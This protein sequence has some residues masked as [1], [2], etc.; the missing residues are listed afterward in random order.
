MMKYFSSMISLKT[1]AKLFSTVAAKTPISPSQIVIAKKSNIKQS[2]LKIK[3]LVSLIRNAWVPDALAQLKFSPKHRAVDISRLVLRANAIAKLQFSAIP[4][5][6]VIKEVI[7]N[8]GIAV[9]KNRIMGRGRTGV[10]YTRSS[11][12]TVKVEKINFDDMIDKS[13]SMNQKKKWSE[14]R[15]AVEQL[16]ATNI[17]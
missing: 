9:K 13:P 14:R 8:K 6:L 7:V 11:H 2:P 12:V 16:K 17:K 10:G 15:D 5:E 4:E 3:F 1:A